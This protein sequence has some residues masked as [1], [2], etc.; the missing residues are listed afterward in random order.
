[1]RRILSVLFVARTRGTGDEIHFKGKSADRIQIIIQ[2]K[3]ENNFS[4]FCHLIC[5]S[6]AADLFLLFPIIPI[7]CAT[8]FLFC[9][10]S[11]ASIRRLVRWCEPNAAYLFRERRG[12]HMTT[13]TKNNKIDLIWKLLSFKWKLFRAWDYRRQKEKLCERILKRKERKIL[14]EAEE[15][16]TSQ[17]SCWHH[18]FGWRYEFY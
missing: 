8:I 4:S 7:L 2:N 9:A 17:I 5:F 18:A 14:E 3:R 15:R 6:F 1:M 13:T 16:R 11:F 12:E 10:L